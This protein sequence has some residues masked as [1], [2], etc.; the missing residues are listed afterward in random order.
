M[1]KL[2]ALAFCS[3]LF[4]LGCTDTN[5]SS[6]E[7]ADGTPGFAITTSPTFQQVTETGMTTFTVNVNPFNGYTGMVTLSPLGL[8]AN[9]TAGFSPQP[10]NIVDANSQN[11]TMTITTSGAPDGSYTIDV[12][13]TDG[14]TNGQSANC[15]ANLQVGPY[16]DWSLSVTPSSITVSRGQAATYGDTVT[17]NSTFSGTI[18]MST[19]GEP[20]NTTS[21]FN[22]TSFTLSP[23]QVGNGTLKVQTTSHTPRGTYNLNVRA[24]QGIS[25]HNQTVV[26]VV[27]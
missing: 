8:P 9:T 1:K 10:V 7:Q 21:T 18:S 11:S 19:S 16:P 13:G 25:G 4:A 14:T 3:A 23:N 2:A 26:L 12:A 17:A 24:Y 6:V 15:C 27:Q 22:P 5:S 20:S